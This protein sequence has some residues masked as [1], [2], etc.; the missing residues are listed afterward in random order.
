MQE[1]T[2]SQSIEQVESLPEGAVSSKLVQGPDGELYF[3][4][5]TAANSDPGL[6]ESEIA[7]E[8]VTGMFAWADPI[9]ADP[10]GWAQTNLL[11]AGTLIP[12]IWQIGAILVALLIDRSVRHRGVASLSRAS[13]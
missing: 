9:L 4:P 3:V 10:F 12:I 11:N 6:A 5:D 1:D 8:P 13:S 2:Q 7:S